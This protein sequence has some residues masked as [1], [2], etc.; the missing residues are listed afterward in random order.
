MLRI[1]LRKQGCTNRKTFRLVLIDALTRRDGKYLEMLGH[2]DPE[3]KDDSG[4]KVKED[5][6]AYWLSKGAQMS[7][8]AEA[9]I[10]RVAPGALK[11]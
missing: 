3:A 2:V 5:R 6:V 1:R 4:A 10:R 7:E 9:L 8:R 11:R